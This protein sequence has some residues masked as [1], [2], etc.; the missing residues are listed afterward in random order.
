MLGPSD[1]ARSGSG[2]VLDEQTGNTHR[3]GGAGQN[4]HEFALPARG[5]PLSA[6]LLHGMGRVE[7]HRRAGLLRHDGQAAHVGDQGIVSRKRRR[8]R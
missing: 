6:R 5:R 3:D 8:A 2:C 4:R 7:D 1:R